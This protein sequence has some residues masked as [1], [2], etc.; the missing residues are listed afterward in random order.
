MKKESIQENVVIASL[1]FLA[2]ICRI[3]TN[4]LELW[5]FNAIGASALFGGIVIKNKRLAYLLPLLTL[6][7][8][9]VF[10]QLFTSIQGFYG[11]QMFFVYGAFLLIT[12]VGTLIKKINALNILLAAISTGALF[13]LI[14]NLGVWIL[15]TMYPHTGAGLIACYAAAIPFYKNDLFGSFALNTILGNVFFTGVLFGAWAIIKQTTFQQ[16]KQLA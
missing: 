12:F 13:F 3:A 6:F 14:S 8:T 16:N 5:N 7:L 10:F 15:S 1:I 4:H 9:D 11:G 2:I